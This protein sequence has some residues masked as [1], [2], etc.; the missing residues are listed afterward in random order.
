MCCVIFHSRIGDNSTSNVKPIH[1][2]EQAARE[3]KQQQ[4]TLYVWC[5]TL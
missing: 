2:V 4:T 3:K 5:Y 1:C